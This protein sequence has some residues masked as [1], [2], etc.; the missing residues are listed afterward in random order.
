MGS[1]QD[2]NNFSLNGG[3]GF[4]YRLERIVFVFW[5]DTMD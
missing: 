5:V 1:D 2:D 3:G 4:F